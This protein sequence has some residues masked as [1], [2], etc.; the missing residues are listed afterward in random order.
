MNVWARTRPMLYIYIHTYIYYA[1]VD[2]VAR[3][4]SSDW[5]VVFS[6]QVF[7][8]FLF[9]PSAWTVFS[10]RRETSVSFRLYFSIHFTSYFLFLLLLLLMV[11]FGW[12]FLTLFSNASLLF[13]FL[14]SY[15]LSFLILFPFYSWRLVALQMFAPV[16]HI[17]VE[18]KRDDVKNMYI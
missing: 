1:P 13:Y 11:Y 10:R 14:F 5:R 2:S 15:F 6:K 7:Y 3:E 17:R 18:T 8:H 4:L 16:S 9:R 12:L